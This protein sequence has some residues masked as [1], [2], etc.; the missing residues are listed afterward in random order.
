MMQPADKLL[1][2][3]FLRR[4]EAVEQGAGRLFRVR[5]QVFIFFNFLSYLFFC[6]RAGHLFR[7]HTQVWV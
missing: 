1:N 7:V 3:D 5:T 6:R 4:V 2:A